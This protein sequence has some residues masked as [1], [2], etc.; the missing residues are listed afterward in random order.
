MMCRQRGERRRG[1][2]RVV[3]PLVGGYRLAVPPVPPPGELLVV[4]LLGEEEEVEQVGKVVVS[5]TLM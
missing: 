2:V 3:C 1:R 4:S 5:A